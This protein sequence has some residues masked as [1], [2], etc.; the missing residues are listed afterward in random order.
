MRLVIHQAADEETEL[1]AAAE[2]PMNDRLAER[3]IE[4]TKRRIEL[5]SR[6]LVSWLH[7]RRGRSRQA[8]RHEQLCL[9]PGLSR[10]EQ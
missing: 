1:L 3:G 10:S 8:R 2:R 9:Q 6:T 5:L 4:T 7:V